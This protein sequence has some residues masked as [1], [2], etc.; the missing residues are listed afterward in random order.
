MSPAPPQ[1]GS[2]RQ[3]TVPRSAQQ[4]RV[5]PAASRTVPQAAKTTVA[6][7]LTR[8]NV[9][10]ATLTRALIER[11][12]YLWMAF[13]NPYNLSMLAG[14]I[15]IAA[16]IQEPLMA[17]AAL[18]AE[19]LWLV[20]GPG[21]R[22]LQ[23][24]LWDPA[25]ERERRALEARARENLLAALHPAER[26]RVEEL[27][28]RQEQIRSLASLNPSFTGEL[29]RDELQKTNRLVD[30]FVELA[31]SCLRYEQYLDS[32]DVP[33]LDRDRIRYSENVRVGSPDDPQ[34]GIARKNLEI[35]DKRLER[36]E[37]IRRYLN[38]ARGQLDLIENSFQLIADQIITMQSPKELSGQLD[39]MLDGVEAIRETARDTERI[40]GTIDKEL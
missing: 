32:I 4:A 11:K 12:P 38:V 40:L 1:K 28:A 15:S 22:L 26:R 30:A 9:T 35:V 6:P 24:Y 7:T 20:F 18:S 17:L 23:R 19:A 36:M 34:T 21:S 37:E 16:M 14:S 27:V 25:L 29:L 39:E 8:D 31:L 2:G 13:A 33:E 3:E 5:P 10:P